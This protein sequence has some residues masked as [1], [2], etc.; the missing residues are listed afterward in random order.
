MEGNVI[1]VAM[2]TA[3]FAPKDEDEEGEWGDVDI[4]EIDFD[5]N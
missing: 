5:G 3:V 4:D 2:L 1:G